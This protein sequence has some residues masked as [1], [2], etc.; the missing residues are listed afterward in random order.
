[1]STETNERYYPTWMLP[2]YWAEWDGDEWA[3]HESFSAH[4]ALQLN[5]QQEVWL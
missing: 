2:R 3:A 5:H 1:M 4:E